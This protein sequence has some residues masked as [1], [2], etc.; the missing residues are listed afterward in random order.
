MK[1]IAGLM[2]A[3]VLVLGTGAATYSQYDYG[4]P[5]G[6]GVAPG[7]G[8]K[9]Q[10]KTAITHAGFAAS[11]DSIG[12]VRQHLG[13]ALNCIE[14]P[15][16]KNF[17]RTWGHVCQGQGN[18]ILQDL[19]SA[20]GGVTFT[21]VVEHADSLAAA[22]VTRKDLA[23]AKAAAKATQALLAVIDGGLK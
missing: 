7:S 11:G 19:R 3:A 1:S 4:K 14:G 13:H 15:N 12:Y 21:I 8:V 9:G 23:E 6:G 18:G 5:P 16:G 2:L 22:G 10:L 20:P 17:N